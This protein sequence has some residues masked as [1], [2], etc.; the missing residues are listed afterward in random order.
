MRIDRIVVWGCML[1][2]VKAGAQSWCPPGAE[3]SHDY[4]AI[5]WTT[6][7][8]HVGTKLA[9]YAGDTTIAGHAAQRIKMHLFYEVI[10]TGQQFSQSAG[11][12]HTR[13]AEDVVYQWEP[14][15][16]QFDTLFWFGAVPGDHWSVWGSGGEDYH[17]LATDTATV[18]VDGIPLRRV[19]VSMMYPELLGT[20]PAFYDTLYERIGSTA[21]SSFEPPHPAADGYDLWFRCYRDDA[22]SYPDQS[23]ADCGFTLAA[24]DIAALE[25][26]GVYPNPGHD[27]F[28][29]AGPARTHGSAT[30]RV[31]DGKGAV[32]GTWGA[33]GGSVQVD[34][35]HWP[36]G[37]YF[38]EWTD[39]HHRRTSTWMKW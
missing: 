16:G 39:T 24:G 31:L 4:Q 8:T 18:T 28:W 20:E 3:W 7:E 25:P 36:A 11:T 33:T 15:A 22:C 23:P 21:Y 34:A 19:A 1:L 2:A 14:S 26:F 17:F 30:I 10:G 38:I 27:R 9:W 13:Y 5:N 32:L 35:T 12:V 37:L 6:G 29:I